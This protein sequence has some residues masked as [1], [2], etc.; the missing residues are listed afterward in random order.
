V[1]G[2]KI[3][4]VEKQ[5]KL[6]SESRFV[7]ERTY[8]SFRYAIPGYTFLILVLLI[9]I[10]FLFSQMKLFSEIITIFGIIL[11]LLSLLSGSAIGFIVSQLWYLVY[12]CYYKR[13][14]KLMERDSYKKLID[15]I[16]FT[17]D[18]TDLVSIMAY[19]LTSKI[20]NKITNYIN[21]LI[22]MRNSLASTLF[23]IL[24][25]LLLGYSYRLIT[26][27]IFRSYDVVIFDCAVIFMLFIYL[28]YFQR[29][30]LHL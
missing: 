8:F 5:V 12:N 30:Q 3:Y 14:R 16:E 20:D 21:R 25:G 19:I 29:P 23:A 4:I 1:C 27:P 7:S 15:L 6:M 17:G 22:D 28:N 24:T 13:Y 18:A 9:N 2:K 10:E 11:G 26:F